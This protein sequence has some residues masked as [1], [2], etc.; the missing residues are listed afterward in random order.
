MQKKTAQESH[1][2]DFQDQFVA[3][4]SNVS[5]IPPIEF[6]KENQWFQV[7]QK[8]R[9]STLSFVDNGS[10]YKLCNCAVLHIQIAVCI[11][12]PSKQKLTKLWAERQCY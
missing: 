9:K 7:A 10:L 3:N 6:R 1:K 11:R 12:L 4:N 2:V 5:K 8:R